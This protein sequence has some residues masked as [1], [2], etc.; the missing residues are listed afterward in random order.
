VPKASEVPRC[1]TLSTGVR[2]A[3]DSVC[4]LAG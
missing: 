1:I 3:E 4:S 2:A